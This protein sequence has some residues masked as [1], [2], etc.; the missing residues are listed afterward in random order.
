MILDQMNLTNNPVQKKILCSEMHTQPHAAP[1]VIE[2]K[3]VSHRF[4]LSATFAEKAA[5]A[6]ESIFIEYLTS[7]DIP[8]HL[9]QASL[10]V[11]VASKADER[12][13]RN[14]IDFCGRKDVPVLFESEIPG[15][16]PGDENIPN[17]YNILHLKDWDHKISVKL[18]NDAD[19][20]GNK[21]TLKVL[22]IPRYQ[23]L[24]MSSTVTYPEKQRYFIYGDSTRT[25]MT[26]VMSK[27][28]D[29]QHTVTLSK[30]P[31]SLTETMLD[32][33][34]MA[35]VEEL[36]GSPLETGGKIRQPFQRSSYDVSFIGEISATIHTTINIKK[37]VFFN[38]IVAPTANG[39]V[40]TPL[41]NGH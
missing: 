15:Y 18:V 31:H 4:I 41:T 32:L 40:K 37:T 38:T 30:R 3:V 36:E 28:P 10:K 39:L 34:V 33:G 8:E 5:G 9:Y 27:L 13:L 12:M 23:R 24:D 26:H 7:A 11:E 29:F 22:D 6:G 35:E 25:I 16:E 1:R 17:L 19:G 20:F 2:E 14:Y 21:I